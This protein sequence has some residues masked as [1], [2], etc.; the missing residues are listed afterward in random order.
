MPV[1]IDEI[2]SDIELESDSSQAPRPPSGDAGATTSEDVIEQRARDAER[3]R[4]RDF[5]D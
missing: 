3:T 5:D 2:E 1:R 4:A